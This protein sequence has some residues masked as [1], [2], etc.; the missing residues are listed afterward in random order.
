MNQVCEDTLRNICKYLSVSDCIN[1]EYVILKCKTQNY[2]LYD[3]EDYVERRKKEPYNLS[4]DRVVFCSSYDD[5][6]FMVLV[7]QQNV[8]I[9]KYIFQSEPS[10]SSACKKAMKMFLRR[11]GFWYDTLNYDYI[12]PSSY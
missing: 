7:K 11:P 12:S 10:C 1:I 4:V 8:L 9:E 2:V 3:L 5:D 6:A